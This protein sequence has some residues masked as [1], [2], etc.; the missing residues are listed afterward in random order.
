MSGLSLRCAALRG[1]HLD[2]KPR[3]ARLGPV[4]Q[5]CE[6]SGVS[7]HLLNQEPRKHNYT[8]IDPDS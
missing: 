8:S 6:F 4:F 7:L 3:Q 1:V 5:A 2:P